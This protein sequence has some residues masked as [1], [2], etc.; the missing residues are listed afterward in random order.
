MNARQA[1]ER[2]VELV[3]FDGAPTAQIARGSDGVVCVDWLVGGRFLQ[4]DSS[5]FGRVDVFG[6]VPGEA[7][8]RIDVAFNI[9]DPPTN[10]IE[11]CRALLREMAP[12]V[13][14]RVP[15]QLARW[16]CRTCGVGTDSDTPGDTR[17]T[18]Q[19]AAEHI[20]R[21]GGWHD[22]KISQEDE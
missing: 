3:T 10:V 19:R 22:V 15:T 11:A 8:A 21:R 1:V 16:D 20:S 7:D 18:A 5:G 2:F 17:P 12:H 6:Y 4:A 13:K 9:S 14:H